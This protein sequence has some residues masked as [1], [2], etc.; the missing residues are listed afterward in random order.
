MRVRPEPLGEKT[1]RR[2]HEA[3]HA[4]YDHALRRWYGRAEPSCHR[5]RR[6]HLDP[7]P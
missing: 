1:F 2:E 4:R 7:A 6:L 3:I 5:A